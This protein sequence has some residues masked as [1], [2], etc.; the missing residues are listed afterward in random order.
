MFVI[1]LVLNG[2]VYTLWYNVLLAKWIT[3]LP[4]SFLNTTLLPTI[5]D[6][7]VCSPIVIFL[8]FSLVGIM[9]YHSQHEFTQFVSKETPKACL[10]CFLTWPPVQLLNFSCVPRKFQAAVVCIADFFWAIY[11]SWSSSTIRTSQ[12]IKTA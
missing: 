7:F 2:P 6:T 3:K 12:S 4:Q 9:Q 1:G 10:L 11:L 5:L 8:F